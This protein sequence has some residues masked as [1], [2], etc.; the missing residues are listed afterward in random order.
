MEG[1]QPC[2]CGSV[3]VA[4]ARGSWRAS[5]TPAADDPARAADPAVISGVLAMASQGEHALSSV[6]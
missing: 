6:C 5:A 4:L 2:R 3:D 1:W